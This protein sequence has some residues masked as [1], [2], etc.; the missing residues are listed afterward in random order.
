MSDDITTNQAIDL[1]RSQGYV[2]SRPEWGPWISNGELY[3][4]FESLISRTC[5]HKRLNSYGEEFPV[6]RGPKGSILRLRTTPALL[7][8]LGRPS[9]PGQRTDLA[10]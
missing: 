10:R 1:L 5:F 3:S 7:E 6:K 2:I 8:W 9:Q 4:R